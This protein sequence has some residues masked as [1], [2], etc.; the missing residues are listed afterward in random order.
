M[1]L[2]NTTLDDLAAIIGFTA[3]VRLSSWF[4]GRNLYVPKTVE[5][6]GVLA[7]LV[8]MAAAKRLSNEFGYEH[9]AVPSL[10]TALRESRYA[11]MCEMMNNGR[12][13]GEVALAME[14]GIRRVQQ[15]RVEFETL[16]LLPQRPEML[17][18]GGKNGG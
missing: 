7:A 12:S 18:K 2:R 9:L 15:L 3:T 1:Q 16:G 10:A 5:P 13:M 6:E 4:G 8:G 14:M 17:D 11:K